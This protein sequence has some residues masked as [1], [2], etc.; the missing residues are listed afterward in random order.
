MHREPATD[1][2]FCQ[3]HVQ[4]LIASHRRLTGRD[5]VDPS[6][7]PFDAAQYLYHAPFVALSHDSA[8]DPRFTYANLAAQARFEM[9]WQEI[10]G[11]PS[12]LSAEP[13]VQA[14]RARLLAQVA[15][16][17]YIDH[18]SGIRIAKSGRRFS[19][20]NATVWNLVD[21]AGH[22]HGQAATFTECGNLPAP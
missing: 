1:N 3:E 21:T 11:L 6:L 19:I 10:V 15:M 4:L 20:R 2:G 22:L 5:L 7:S 17:G 12:R 8:A 14:E 18:Y 13:L 9:P 16:T